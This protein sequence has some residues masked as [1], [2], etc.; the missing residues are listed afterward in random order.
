[1]LALFK[2][3]LTFACFKRADEMLV[4]GFF[5]CSLKLEQE[6]VAEKHDMM[7]IKG[8]TQTGLRSRK[9][10]GSTFVQISD[11]LFSQKQKPCPLLA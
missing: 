9:R 8:Q 1:M 3:D 6:R 4:I 7:I 11:S 10:G 5:L 2:S